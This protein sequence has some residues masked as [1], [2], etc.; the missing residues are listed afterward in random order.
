MAISDWANIRSRTNEMR[1]RLFDPLAKAAYEISEGVSEW[2]RIRRQREA[3]A[4]AKAEEQARREADSG[5]FAELAALSAGG[6]LTRGALVAFMERQRGKV[7]ATVGA[8][9]LRFFQQQKEEEAKNAAVEEEGM[10]AAEATG[11]PFLKG[12][13][14][15]MYAGIAKKQQ[16]EARVA[17][18]APVLDAV[19]AGKP[20]D[21]TMRARF[22]D[23]ILKEETALRVAAKQMAD[24]TE[25]KEDDAAL[26]QMYADPE[27][28]TPKQKARVARV[29]QANQRIEA[30][31]Q[32]EQERAEEIEA[33]DA[34]SEE[35]LPGIRVT[36][37]EAA[38]LK[39]RRA[40]FFQTVR[41]AQAAADRA[42]KSGDRAER[43]AAI[44]ALQSVRTSS[45]AALDEV[46]PRDTFTRTRVIQ[47]GK[48]RR[49]HELQT[50]ID[51]AA[52]R[53]ADLQK[54]GPAGNA[55]V[56][57]L[58]EKVERGTASAE[59]K[60]EFLRLTEVK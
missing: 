8:G 9:A 20:V 30:K 1:A 45:E 10:A 4:A 37:P 6:N 12:L 38:N 27:K 56:K 24:E 11:V 41:Q 53:I 35:D 34:A 13:P 5:A 26:E 21:S 57:E 16:D 42:E 17:E 22:Q 51:T 2:L 47:P 14:S 19:R 49:A 28:M 33:V 55:R 18:L 23:D 48:E 36:S 59:E 50:A 44:S 32:T 39:A 58:L 15:S 31:A 60:A 7:S 52:A 54:A 3:E 40:G 25:K 29:F 43:S 46:A